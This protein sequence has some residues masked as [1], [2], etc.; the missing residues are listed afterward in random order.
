MKSKFK[1]LLTLCLLLSQTAVWAQHG[2]VHKKSKNYE[3]P[4]DPQTLEKLEQWHDLKFGVL[5]HWGIY[6]VPGMV[7][8]WAI[9]SEDEDWIPR[10]ST[11]AYTDYKQAYFDLSKKFNPTEFDPEQWSRICKNAGMKYMIFTT[12]HHDGFS[13]FDTKETDYSIMNGPFGN[14][15]KANLTK[16][17]FDAFRKDN[18]MIGAY[19]SKPD[20]HSPYYW[21]P[22]YAT[23]NRNVNYKIEKHP[24]QWEKF[25]QFTQNQI[26][27]LMTEY[28]RVDIL[29]LDG[30]WVAAP[31][32]DIRMDEI[33]AKSRASQPGLLVVDRMIHGP[34]ENYQTPERTI[35]EEQLPNPW[36][37]NIPLKD[38]WG[39][40]AKDDYK[41]ST[42]VIDY[43]IE[44]VAK[45]GC[46]VLGVGP[47]PEGIIEPKVEAILNE[48]GQWLDKNGDAIYNTRIVPHYHSGKVWFTAN[49]KTNTMYALYSLKDGDKLPTQIEWEGNLPKGKMKLLANGKNVS[50]KVKGDKVI[51]NLPSSVVKQNQ[52]VAFAY[53]TN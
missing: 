16:H 18:F 37:S 51:V 38:D 12:K 25:V 39:W 4:T 3:W 43:L 7:E 14:N 15:P 50:Y 35:P 33:A 47:T 31:R 26:N 48:I 42:T 32:Q 19:F 11:V 23:P 52:S 29:W 9:C 17:V 46:F 13:M 49:P 27:E 2:F 40:T 24:E 6:S 20:W 21:W 53:K 5:F 30:G 45:G 8:S 41:S 22:R 34:N 44:I 1:L 36:E 10:D 28:G